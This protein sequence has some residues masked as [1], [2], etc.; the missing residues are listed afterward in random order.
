MAAIIIKKL[1]TVWNSGVEDMGR[2]EV[3]GLSGGRGGLNGHN[4]I[5][6]RRE[7]QGRKSERKKK[8]RSGKKKKKSHHLG[9]KVFYTRRRR[10]CE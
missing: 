4:V 7:K 5:M 2:V 9:A 8:K 3:G 1:N 10:K 6:K